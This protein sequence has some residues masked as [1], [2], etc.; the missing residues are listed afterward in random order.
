MVEIDIQTKLNFSEAVIL[1]FEGKSKAHQKG[2]VKSGLTNTLAFN[3]LIRRETPQ[4]DQVSIKVP[5][6][7]DYLQDDVMPS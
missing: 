2:T 6:H 3:Y 1:R 4:I 5:E 7:K